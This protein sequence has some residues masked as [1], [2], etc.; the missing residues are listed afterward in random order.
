MIG[1]K[2]FSKQQALSC[3]ND[4]QVNLFFHASIHR[5]VQNLESGHVGASDL[6]Q[7]QPFAK[8]GMCKHM[9]DAASC[10]D[11]DA[12][13]AND[14]FLNHDVY[15]PLTSHITL[16]IKSVQSLEDVS[17]LD[18][19]ILGT[20]WKIAAFETLS[21]G[22]LLAEL[23]MQGAEKYLLPFIALARDSVGA[24]YLIVCNTEKQISLS[25]LKHLMEHHLAVHRGIQIIKVDI[26][27]LKNENESVLLCIA[28]N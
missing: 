9:L 11:E 15:Q 12:D 4:N 19:D 14:Q 16:S 28:V 20:K 17:F 18:I 2:F 6:Q 26:S 10:K 7:A 23:S 8:Q 21:V 5:A 1:T 25:S 24:E 3:F 27:N 22:E 13:V